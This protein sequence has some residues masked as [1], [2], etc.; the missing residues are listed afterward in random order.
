MTEKNKFIEQIVAL[1]KK[2]S[3]YIDKENEEYKNYAIREQYY[4]SGYLRDPPKDNQQIWERTSD[5]GDFQL[6]EKLKW[7]PE[8]QLWQAI[9]RSWIQTTPNPQFDSEKSGFIANIKTRYY[10]WRE[11]QLQK[12]LLERQNF[13]APPKDKYTYRSKNWPKDGDY[14]R[15]YVWNKDRNNWDEIGRRRII[16]EQGCTH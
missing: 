9:D 12:G 6:R 8:I 7:N 15:D 3:D 1:P 11:K 10:I 13:F 2:I 4:L 5:D 16:V 14:C